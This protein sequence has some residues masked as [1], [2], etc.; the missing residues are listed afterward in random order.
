MVGVVRPCPRAPLVRARAH[1]AKALTPAGGAREPRQRQV[2]PRD[3]R[4]RHPA[5][6][7]SL[8]PSCGVG[9]ARPDGVRGLLFCSSRRRHTSLVS[10]WSSDVCSSDLGKLRIEVE[11][12]TEQVS[13]VLPLQAPNGPIGLA[14]IGR[15]SCRERVWIWAL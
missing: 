1:G 11:I 10:D 7:A 4:S 3:A 2:D 6:R 12:A 14:E 13:K 8:L 5:R 9:A 15:A